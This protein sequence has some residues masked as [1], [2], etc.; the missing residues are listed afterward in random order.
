VLTAS[1]AGMTSGS[2]ALT[3]AAATAVSLTVDPSSATV[4]AR[5]S[6]RLAATGRDVYG[7]RFPAT[8]TWSLT[9]AELGTVSP[10]TGPTATLTA[11]RT[12]G[13]GTVAATLLTPAGTLTATAAVRVTPGTLRIGSIGYRRSKG[14]TL[15]AVATLDTGG[16]AVDGATVSALVSLNGRRYRLA[17][18]TTG[19]SGRV[20]FGLRPGASGCFTT[21]IEQVSAR[22]FVWDGRTPGNRYCVSR[23]RSG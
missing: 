22:G 14:F 3:V 2:Q 23:G 6:R 16:R 12:L 15:V 13:T 9:P 1:G 4:A 19:L 18:A 20:V 11:S 7:N 5:G 21:T 10:G 17:R 8:A